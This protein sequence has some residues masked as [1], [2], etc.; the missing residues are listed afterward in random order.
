MNKGVNLIAVKFELEKVAE[1]NFR[2][3]LA[4]RINDLIV[5]DFTKLVQILYQVDVD[6]SKLRQLLDKR[7]TVDA[8]ETIADLLIEREKKRVADRRDGSSSQDIPEN[9]KW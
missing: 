8:G 3:E 4:R 7:S 5:N 2:L 1:S 9:E 6:E